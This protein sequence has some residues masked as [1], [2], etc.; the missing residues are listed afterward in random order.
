[1]PTKTVRLYTLALVLSDIFAILLAFTAA[2]ILRVQLD[3]R[4]L[5]SSISSY[6]FF[7][8]FIIL[9][10]FWL[11]TF[12]SLDMYAP[13]VYQ[14]R[15]T[16]IGKVFVGSFLGILLVLGFSFLT[17]MPVFPARL[18]AV[19]AA[20]L[21]F[22]LLIAGREVLRQARSI[23]FRYGRGIQRVMIVGSGTAAQDIIRNLRDTEN[24]GYNIVAICGT[25]A[26]HPKARK[27]TNLQ[28]A[29]DSLEELDID[30]IIQTEMFDEVTQNRLVFETA[31]CSH[32]GYSFIPGEVEFYS[33]SN[34]A[35][36]LGGYPIISVSQTP[37][38]GWGEVVKRVFDICV[39]LL[40]IIVLSP[41]F[42][43]LIIL[44]KIFNPGKIIYPHERVT[45]KGRHFNVYKFRSMKRKKGYEN[46]L[47]SD[48]FRAMGREDLAK[49]YEK[50]YKVE[51]DPRITPFGNFLRRSSL[52]ELPQL[53]NILRGDLSLVGPR[54]LIPSELDAKYSKQRG[55]SLLSVRSGLTGLW[56]VSGRSDVTD[57]Q[58]IQLELYYVQ[59]WSFIMDIKILVKTLGVV[60]RRSGAQ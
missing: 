14:K 60:L 28:N 26:S 50:N 53:I 4:P 47:A 59:N 31:V 38:L 39:S 56:Q 24:S 32:V 54:P 6:E 55:A 12:V 7:R 57:E 21:V 34:V 25:G 3:N 8:I 46:A 1:M 58:R 19:Y 23:A 36:V 17:D 45:K 41:I 49:E 51:N 30:T 43:V 20:I 27:F 42:I 2:Y 5:I 13:R 44:Q 9:T 48:E 29:L 35:D 11:L 15:L 52:D 18:V 40:M 16:E 22:I 33:G 10:P 37:L